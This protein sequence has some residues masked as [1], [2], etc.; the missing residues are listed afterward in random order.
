MTLKRDGSIACLVLALTCLWA[1]TATAGPLHDAA[2]ASD[3]V[4]IQ[5]LLDAGADIDERDENGATALIAA[6]LASG[7]D[8]EALETIDY[9]LQRKADHTI[10]DNRGMT[11][12]HAAALSGDAESVAYFTGSDGPGYWP[13]DIDD[14]ANVL[15]VTPLIVAAEANRGNVVAYLAMGGANLEVADNAGQTALTHAGT[16]GH[17]KVATILLRLGAKCQEIDPAW[18]ATCTERRQALGLQ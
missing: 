5:A 8:T 16:L 9:L 7:E 12:L 15:G 1:T 11:V 3:E 13:I 18:F 6:A 4:A 14:K 10:R 17:D 2:R